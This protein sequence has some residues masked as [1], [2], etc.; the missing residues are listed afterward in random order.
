MV[1]LL[2]QKYS[3]SIFVV[4]V[5]DNSTSTKLYRESRTK[6]SNIKHT[7]NTHNIDFQYF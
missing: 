6:L 2:L 1:F 4:K 3:A 7:P 5:K